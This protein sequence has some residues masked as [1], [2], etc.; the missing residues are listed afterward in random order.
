MCN[1]GAV[2]LEQWNIAVGNKILLSMVQWCLDQ[3]I[4]DRLDPLE[5]CGVL[6]ATRG[7][8]QAFPGSASMV[9]FLL[10]QCTMCEEERLVLSQCNLPGDNDWCLVL[11]HCNLPGDIGEK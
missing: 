6:P 2:Q 10:A 1:E 4:C 7:C 3:T 9:H 8:Q 5:L 11:S